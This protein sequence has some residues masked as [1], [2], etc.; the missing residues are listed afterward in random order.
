MNV[1]E[2]RMYFFV[3]YQLMGIQ[4]GIQAGHAAVEYA[5]QFGHHE[6]FNDFSKNHKTWIVLN[7]GTTNNNEDPELCGSMQTIYNSILDFNKSSDDE[8]IIVAKFHEPDLNDA[9]TAICF[10]CDQRVWDKK[11]VPDYDEYVENQ[12]FDP[13]NQDED[14]YLHKWTNLIGGEKNKM[15][16]ELLRGKKFA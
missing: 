12:F 7:G 11:L 3:N 2:R 5:V 9:L 6:V 8:T 4:K 14:R 1:L 16:R 15:L 13:H 10:I